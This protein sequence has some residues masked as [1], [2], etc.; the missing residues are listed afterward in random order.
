MERLKIAVLASGKG[1]NAKALMEAV[2]KEERIDVVLFLSDREDAGVHELA[3]GEGTPSRVIDPEELKD[4]NRLLELLGKYGIRMIVL[5]GFFRKIP[6]EVVKAFR[7]RI[8]NV[9]PA[10]LPDFGGKGMYGEH[11]HRAVL[12]AGRKV[13]GITVHLV[14]EEYDNGA[15]LFQKECPVKKN[16]TPQSL[17]E[18]I[19]RMEHEY[20]PRIVIERAKELLN[21]G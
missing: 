18:R 7:G 4:G 8:L 1:S 21:E 16:D 19:K 6:P 15:T 2:R 20:Y 12:E 13:S 3:E 17:G 14:D 5:A 10:L 9:H 11:V